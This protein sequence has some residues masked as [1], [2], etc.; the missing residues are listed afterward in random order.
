MVEHTV[1]VVGSQHSPVEFSE[2]LALGKQPLQVGLVGQ[3]VGAHPLGIGPDALATLEFGHVEHPPEHKAHVMC[4]VHN[5]EDACC[6]QVISPLNHR[7]V[8][9]PL[10]GPHLEGHS[11]KHRVLIVE[12][13]TKR[14]I[15]PI[16]SHCPL[17]FT[18]RHDIDALSRQH[19]DFPSIMRHARDDVVV[20]D[21]PLFA[22]ATVLY[23]HMA[24]L[25]THFH[26]CLR[27]L[28]ENRRMWLP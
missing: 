25:L 1:L 20:R 9:P 23:P 12:S 14:V 11:Q 16:G 8:N 3:F 2:L 21:V 13:P 18:Y 17:V 6:L 24:I 4:V 7:V 10:R 19:L 15:H 26:P 5:R 22:D 27:I 28:Y